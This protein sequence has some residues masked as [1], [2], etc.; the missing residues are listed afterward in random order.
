MKGKIIFL[1]LFITLLGCSR[2]PQK[3]VFVC[4]GH[5]VYAI[6]NEI[7]GGRSEVVRLVPPG[8][9]PHTYSPI[10]SDMNKVQASNALFYVS[11]ELDAWA[12][13]LPAK[14]KIEL[15]KLLPREFRKNFD[16]G[17]SHNEGKHIHA[18]GEEQIDPHFWTDPLTVKA[19][20]PNL[21]ETLSSIDPA[22]AK[23]Y[24][25]NA[26]AF[27]KRLDLLNTQVEGM[28]Q[29]VKGKP[30]FLFHP[31]FRYFLKRYGLVY[32]GAIELTPGVE[33]SLKQ[34]GSLIDRIK[35]SGTKAIFTEPQLP[36]RPANVIAESAGVLV[37]MLDPNGGVKGRE[38]YSE[39][40]LYNA[41]ILQKA[42]K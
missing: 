35:S 29:K 31:S 40:V 8:A 36:E 13:G 18:T 24:K 20:L 27:G 4:T 32:A 23:T 30:V 38:N 28:L 15:I 7:V 22:N 1:I 33:P 21:V 11:N 9:S 2:A 5:P 37:Y 39:L 41:G 17:H 6:I 25:S 26:D 19:L 10:P 14:N 42:F 16:D 3:H 34:T 12:K